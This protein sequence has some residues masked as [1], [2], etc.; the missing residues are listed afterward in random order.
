[1]SLPD[2]R[3]TCPDG[4]FCHHDCSPESCF[5]VRACL[6]LSSYGENWTDK[7]R[8]ERGNPPDEPTIED[9]IVGG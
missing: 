4:G 9:V 8:A 2:L 1:M 6:P 5:R 7:D 3:L